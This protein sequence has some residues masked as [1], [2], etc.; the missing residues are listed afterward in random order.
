MLRGSIPLTGI[1]LPFISAGGSSLI[2]FMCAVG[3]L[4]NIAKNSKSEKFKDFRLKG[5]S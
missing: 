5:L 1:P 2:V 3:I 4:I